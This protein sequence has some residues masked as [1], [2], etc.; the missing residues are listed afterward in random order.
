MSE[1]LQQSSTPYERVLQL[2][3]WSEEE[4]SRL[5]RFNHPNYVEDESF[6][7]FDSPFTLPLGVDTI[8]NLPI[9]TLRGYWNIMLSDSS[10]ATERIIDVLMEEQ[11]LK[12][13][14]KKLI[15]KR[16]R[17]YAYAN[18]YGQAMMSAILDEDDGNPER[19]E[20]E[21]RHFHWSPL[22]SLH[23][24]SSSSPTTSTDITSAHGS[25]DSSEITSE[26]PYEAT[27]PPPELIISCGLGRSKAARK[28][29][30]DLDKAKQLQIQKSIDLCISKSL[31]S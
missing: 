11:K 30:H 6:K 8:D 19:L 22:H 23:S 3:N 12:D 29:I 28:Q 10:E 17:A 2:R 31:E 20:I 4:K 27:P 5:Q 1:Q 7:F 14:K 21:Y 18:A 16:D 15:N 26:S 25:I 9:S 24:P 13:I